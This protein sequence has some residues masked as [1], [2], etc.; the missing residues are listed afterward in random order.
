MPKYHQNEINFGDDIECESLGFKRNVNIKFNRIRYIQAYFTII[1]KGNKL[2]H[3]TFYMIKGYDIK[4]TDTYRITI[5]CTLSALI[6]FIAG[7][8]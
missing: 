6:I 1:S 4:R 7:K 8:T 5:I 3:T 2:S